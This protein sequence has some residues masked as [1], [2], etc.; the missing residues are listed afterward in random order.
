MRRRHRHGGG[1][2]HG[3][4]DVVGRVGEEVAL[5]LEAGGELEEGAGGVVGAC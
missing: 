4:E 3:A 5:R 2:E 1:L